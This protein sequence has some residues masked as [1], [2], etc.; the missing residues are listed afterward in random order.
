MESTKHVSGKFKEIEQHVP[1]RPVLDP[2]L[3]SSH[4]K[5]LP[6]NKQGAKMCSVCW[7]YR[8]LNNGYKWRRSKSENK[9]SY[10]GATNLVSCKWV[11]DKYWEKYNNVLPHLEEQT[12]LKTPN[13]IEGLDIKCK[14]KTKFLVYIW[15]K[16]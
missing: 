14:Y 2:V 7:C 15:L 1:Q 16:I 6:V 13:H 9:Q 10:A 12:C 3:F 4:I 11:S 8:F 5:D